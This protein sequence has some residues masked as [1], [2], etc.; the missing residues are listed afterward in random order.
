ML[1]DSLV[2]KRN[3][4]RVE[5]SLNFKL[6]LVPQTVLSLLNILAAL[7]TMLIVTPR[8]IEK[9]EPEATKDFYPKEIQVPEVWLSSYK[10]HK[11]PL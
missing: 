5:V 1:S 3:D 11:V 8:T 9:K 7:I 4:F 10:Q 6:L 2:R